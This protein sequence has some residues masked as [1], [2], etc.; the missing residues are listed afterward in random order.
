MYFGDYL[1]NEKIIT[2]NQ[3]LE[4]LCFQLESMPSF[5]KILFE[6]QLVSS[7]KLLGLIKEQIKNDFD[8]ITVLESKNLLTKDQINLIM[9]IQ[10]NQKMPLGEV[11]VKLQFISSTQLHDHLENYYKVKD[12]YGSKD[13]SAEIELNKEN[14]NENSNISDAALDSLRELGI[15]VSELTSEINSNNHAIPK[16]T[17]SSDSIIKPEIR[18]ESLRKCF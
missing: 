1:V 14:T 13:H 5:F 6:K 10:V 15:D 4:A 18:S 8:L 2:T 3:L 11:L 17:V 12:T 16:I 7:D 9:Q